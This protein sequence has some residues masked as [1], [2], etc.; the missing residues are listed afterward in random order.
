VE[1]LRHDDRATDRRRYPRLKASI[2]VEIQRDEG[3]A[4]LHTVVQDISLCGCY[5][6]TMFTYEPGTLVLLVLWVADERIRT[7]AIVTT[8]Y[9]QLGNGFDFIDMLPDDRLR[10]NSFIAAL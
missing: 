4:P 6:E 5:V 7:T 9:P 2:Q 1:L 3:G 10:L 8:R